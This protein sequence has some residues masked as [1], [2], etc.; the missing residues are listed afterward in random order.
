MKKSLNNADNNCGTD[1]TSIKF[2]SHKR[3]ILQII[4]KQEKNTHFMK[5]QKKRK[6]KTP[7]T[8]Y[9]EINHHF[10]RIKGI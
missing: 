7:Q 8:F 10:T 4:M 9:P 5:K 3:K 2:F 1:N 6:I